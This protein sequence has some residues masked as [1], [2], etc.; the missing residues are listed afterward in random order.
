[1]PHGANT[2][3]AEPGAPCGGSEPADSEKRDVM[4]HG[5]RLSSVQIWMQ[6]AENTVAQRVPELLRDFNDQDSTGP[7][8]FPGYDHS[9]HG[10]KDVLYD[11]MGVDHVQRSGNDWSCG[12]LSLVDD[13]VIAAAALSCGPGRRLE[14]CG[15]PT[16][17][18]SM[19]HEYSKSA[20]DVEQS[21]LAHATFDFDQ[22][23]SEDRGHFGVPPD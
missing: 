7:Q 8:Q 18:D 14:S 11:V 10:I 13:D 21:S 6:R 20:P 22:A 23:L 15:I 9:A 16:L 17:L 19:L 4:R 3:D 2:F 5:R 1:V 12:E